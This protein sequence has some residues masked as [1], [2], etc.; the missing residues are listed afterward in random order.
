MSSESG[1]QKENKNLV[2]TGSILMASLSSTP[3]KQAAPFLSDVI[4][5]NWLS[6]LVG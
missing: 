4:F 2:T 6:G 3:P 1:G 5:F